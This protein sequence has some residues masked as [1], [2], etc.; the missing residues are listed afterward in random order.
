MQNQASYNMIP[1]F[2]LIDQNFILRSDSTGH[3]PKE[4]FDHLIRLAAKLVKKGRV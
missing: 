2:Q 1:G 4:S 3:N